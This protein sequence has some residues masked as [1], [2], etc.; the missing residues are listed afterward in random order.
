MQDF[1]RVFD[2]HKTFENI[3]YW[4]LVGERSVWPLFPLLWTRCA[5][6]FALDDLYNIHR[7]EINDNIVLFESPLLSNKHIPFHLSSSLVNYNKELYPLKLLNFQL[8][9]LLYQ[10]LMVVRKYSIGN[11]EII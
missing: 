1:G 2:V 9:L 7:K 8:Y 4:V 11:D 5:I 6:E 3:P 10:C